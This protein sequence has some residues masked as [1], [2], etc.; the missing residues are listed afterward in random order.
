MAEDLD[1]INE[2][3]TAS[4]KTPDPGTGQNLAQA[5]IA[6]GLVALCTRLDRLIV[7]IETTD[8]KGEP[9]LVGALKS[10]TII[11]NAEEINAGGK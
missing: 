9:I 10:M 3:I 8:D 2:L 5:A 1:N 7:D 6:L 4:V 11:A